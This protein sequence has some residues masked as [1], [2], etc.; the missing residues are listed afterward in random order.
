MT[1]KPWG[2]MIIQKGNQNF[3]HQAPIYNDAVT[4]EP[5]H[6]EIRQLTHQHI[7][8][9]DAHPIAMRHRKGSADAAHG[10]EDK[11][12]DEYMVLYDK[13]GKG[14]CTS[15]EM[16]R[17]QEIK[18]S[19]GGIN[20]QRQNEAA[21]ILGRQVQADM[22]TSPA[23]GSTSSDT[24]M[25]TST[26][27]SQPS[28]GSYYAK[29]PSLQ[30]R[31]IPLSKAGVP[32]VPPIQDEDKQPEISPPVAHGIDKAAK[33]ESVTQAVSEVAPEEDPKTKY[34]SI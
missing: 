25:E 10:E 7:G 4:E 6:E 17:I 18:A 2:N 13:A 30:Q 11:L 26:Q 8:A 5:K 20:Q 22:N 28:P 27:L 1:Y 3:G 24:G 32:P 12:V 23:D 29:G 19:L 34:E 14:A 21:R 16:G 15:Q 9:P 31:A 33:P